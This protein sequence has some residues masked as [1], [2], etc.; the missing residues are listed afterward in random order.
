[1]SLRD[2]FLTSARGQ[3][4]VFM[5]GI[6]LA[7]I[8]AAFV[9]AAIPGHETSGSLMT[10]HHSTKA[11]GSTCLPSTVIAMREQFR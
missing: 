9:H 3:L 11:P 5:I 7:A 4:R 8:Y 1:M 10:D 2:A 6:I